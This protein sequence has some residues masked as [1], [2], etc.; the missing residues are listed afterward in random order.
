[1]LVVRTLVI[2]A[3]CG[4]AS[5]CA[6]GGFAEP[7]SV[8][9]CRVTQHGEAGQT[10]IIHARV[11]GAL[12]TDEHCPDNSIAFAFAENI[13]AAPQ[14]AA[15]RRAET[16]LWTRP[17]Y[18]AHVIFAVG[19]LQDPA[20]SVP[21]DVAPRLFLITELRS[22]STEANTLQQA[23]FLL[24]RSDGFCACLETSLGPRVSQ[25]TMESLI[26]LTRVPPDERAQFQSAIEHAPYADDRTRQTFASC[27]SN[28]SW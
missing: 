10:Y 27:A 26:A 21:S 14:V 16:E 9:L 13:Q 3:I 7:R 28:R 1:M 22:F 24:G 19:R 23:C 18:D 25:R 4:M 5:A 20:T 12:L 17:P 15:F 11:S 6:R 2:A 8:D